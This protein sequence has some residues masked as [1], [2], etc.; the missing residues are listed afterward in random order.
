MATSLLHKARLRL[1]SI[2]PLRALYSRVVRAPGWEPGWELRVDRVLAC[3]DNAHIK[4]VPDAGKIVDGVQTMHNGVLINRASYYNEPLSDLLVTS[5]GVHEPQEERCFGQV[6]PLMPE[7]A[8]ILE[9]GAYWGFYSLWF[10][11]EV[12]GGRCY[13]V[14]AEPENL[15]AGRK[16]FELNGR[17]GTFRT[18]FVGAKEEKGPVDLVT[19]DGL[20]REYQLERIHMLHADIQSAEL[21]MLRG[22]ARAISERRIDYFFISTHSNALHYACREHLEG[23]GYVVLAS[24][25][26][27]ETCSVDGLLVARRSELAGPDHL[28]L[29]KMPHEVPRWA[30][31]RWWRGVVEYRVLGK[32]YASPS[33]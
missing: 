4:R 5:R 9:L 18:G 20:M 3:P 24:A 8:V 17:K 14:E 13:L 30:N 10:A 12:S 31:P 29:T 33:K 23:N 28:E 19:V 6:L 1:R 32:R 16:N 25:D 11:A 15:E 21:D 26:I 22:A 7:G 2:E 27:N